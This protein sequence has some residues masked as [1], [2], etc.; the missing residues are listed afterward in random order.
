[1]RNTER[2]INRKLSITACSFTALRASEGGTISDAS[3]ATVGG[4]KIEPLQKRE[5]G[6]RASAAQRGNSGA[7]LT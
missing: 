5:P 3:G 6:D 7:G 4:E 2:K 1:M